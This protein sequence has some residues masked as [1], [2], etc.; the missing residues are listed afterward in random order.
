MRIAE[1]LL[2]RL[3]NNSENTNIQTRQEFNLDTKLL[4]LTKVFPNFFDCIRN[5]EILDFGCGEGFHSIAMA[6]KGAKYVL[7]VDINQKGLNEARNLARRIGVEEKVSFEERLQDRFF[8]KFDIVISKNSMEHFKEPLQILE[9]MKQALK[10]NGRI[11]I[12][13]GPPWLSPYGSHMDFFT[14]IPWVNILFSEETVLAARSHFKHDG[15]TKYEEA[16]SGLNKMTVGK[17]ENIISNSGMSVQYKKY[18]CVKDINLLG[19]LP[20]IRELFVNRIVCIL[21]R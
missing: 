8:G 7:G 9:Q 10:P 2:L 17:F 21:S 20:L 15:A 11:F 6:K 4:T 19:S 18:Y 14:K 12:S 13:F 16:E 5:K 3:S 1:K